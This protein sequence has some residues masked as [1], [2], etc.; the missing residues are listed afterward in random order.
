M[1]HVHLTWPRLLRILY[2]SEKPGRGALDL[3]LVLIESCAECRANSA[4]LV[5]ML[6]A[7]EIPDDIGYFGLA[8]LRSRRRAR[9]TW[10]GLK[11]RSPEMLTQSLKQVPA[12]YGMVD[13]L[14]EESH[15]Q[16][17]ID[18]NLAHRF[19][20]AA[21]RM[22]LSLP[23]RLPEDRTLVGPDDEEPL[24]PPVRTEMFALVYG[25]LG[26]AY[27][28]LY[29]FQDAAEAFDTALAYLKE[30]EHGAC[31]LH[32]RAR[33]LSLQ[34]SLL[35]DTRR[36]EEA[37]Q[38]LEAASEAAADEKAP[39]ALR[40]EIAIKQSLVLGL[41]DPSEEAIAPLRQ[42]LET[43]EGEFSPSVA[44]RLQHTFTT[45]LV[46]AGLITA[47]RTLLPEVYRLSIDGAPG[48]DALRVRWLEGRILCA[49]GHRQEALDLFEALQKD[50][51]EEKAIHEAALLAL[52]IAGVLL[53]LDRQAETVEHARQALALFLPLQLSKE[54]HSALALLAQA[55]ER[56]SV[57]QHLI[58]AL[59]RYAQGGPLPS[60]LLWI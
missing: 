27:R 56:Q 4:D 40:A 48:L 36:L 39:L 6:E 28:K 1:S 43:S 35:M 53:D 14:V 2:K 33:V 12:T 11:D 38:V 47:A 5:E 34:G 3:P 50:F 41:A 7:G 16:A 30:G 51:L 37:I 17:S 8:L 29:Q 26:N 32:G 10:E 59:L 19:A 31:F 25:V 22:A 18:R 23:V 49:E 60:P 20:K 55:A 24:D 58:T 13:L 42:L 44:F 9:A 54:M 52:E 57:S 45:Q 21:L 46:C 15:Q